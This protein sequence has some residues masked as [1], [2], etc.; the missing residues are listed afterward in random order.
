[1]N[2]AAEAPSCF[3]CGLPAVDGDDLQVRIDGQRR[4][5]CCR[6]C[7]AVAQAIVD[8]GMSSYYAQRTALPGGRAEPVPEL[9]A[10]AV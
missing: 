7:Q 2:Q 4:P 5:M 8:A 9:A 10:L 3:H 1:V 6:G